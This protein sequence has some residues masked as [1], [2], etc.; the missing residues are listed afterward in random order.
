MQIKQS[1]VY[2]KVLVTEFYVFL[3]RRGTVPDFLFFRAFKN[4]LQEKNHATFLGLPQ[5]ISGKNM[6]NFDFSSCTTYLL[7]CN[8]DISELRIRVLYA[9]ILRIRVCLYAYT[10]IRVC[11][12]AHICPFVM[13]S[14]KF[15]YMKHCWSNKGHVGMKRLQSE[16]CILLKRHADE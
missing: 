13:H 15:L 7:Q 8:S 5:A 10:R 2:D 11:Q 9:R 6:T 16:I 1:E 4:I 12:Y 14:N 3:T